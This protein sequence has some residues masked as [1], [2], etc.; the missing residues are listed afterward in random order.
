MSGLGSGMRVG[1]FVVI[2]GNKSGPRLKQGWSRFL[3]NF[4][5][6]NGL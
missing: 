1:I 4:S 6:K 3:L 5:T 2:G